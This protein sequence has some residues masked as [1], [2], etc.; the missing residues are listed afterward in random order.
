MTTDRGSIGFPKTNTDFGSNGINF[1]TVY[2]QTQQPTMSHNYQLAYKAYLQSLLFVNSNLSQPFNNNQVKGMMAS[3]LSDS[4]PKNNSEKE[5][6][7]SSMTHSDSLQPFNNQVESV[8]VKPVLCQECA[9]S[10]ITNSDSLKPCN[11]QVESMAMSHSFTDLSTLSRQV[12]ANTP[13][14]LDNYIGIGDDH[15]VAGN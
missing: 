7:S 8:A 1:D 9:P 2:P 13:L 12:S 14:G 5:F 15:Y 3:A 10:S 6:A 4:S 11:N